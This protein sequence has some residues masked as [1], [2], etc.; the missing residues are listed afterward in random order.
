LLNV[1]KVSKV[2]GGKVSY[3]ALSNLDLTVEDNEFVEIMGLSGSGKSTLL[4][5]IA[6]YAAYFLASLFA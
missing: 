6:T 5:M 1:K 2:C 3:R 4:N